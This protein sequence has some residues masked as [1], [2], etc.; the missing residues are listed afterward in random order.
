MDR[1]P[2]PP[3]D[4]S[5]VGETPK[6]PP[7]R[8]DGQRG[9]PGYQGKHRADGQTPG[10]TTPPRPDA[11]DHGLADLELPSPEPTKRAAGEGVL[12]HRDHLQARRR[13]RSSS[14]GTS[15]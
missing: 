4:V 9:E 12:R 7:R 10:M 5:T 8:A 11:R 15:S 14:L 6:E 3:S 1:L 2:P 13:P